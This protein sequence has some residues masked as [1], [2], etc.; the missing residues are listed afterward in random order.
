MKKLTIAALLLTLCAAVL[1]GCRSRNSVNNTTVSTTVATERPSTATTMPTT[2]TTRA[3]TQPATE[4]T[5]EEEMP[6]TKDSEENTGE[7]IPGE[8]VDGRMRRRIPG[9]NRG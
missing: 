1:A 7:V 3:T 5:G 9:H 2:E 4:S 6:E 8:G